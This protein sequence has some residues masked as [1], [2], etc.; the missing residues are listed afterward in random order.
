[1]CVPK[2]IG[3]PDKDTLFEHEA[4]HTVHEQS[5]EDNKERSLC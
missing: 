2:V 5:R 1:M 4:A 3:E